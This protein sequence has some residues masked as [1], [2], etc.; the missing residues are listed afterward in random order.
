[1][2]GI[3]FLIRNG[4]RRRDAPA[5]YGLHKTNY[6]R[7]IRWSRLGVFNCIFAELPAKPDQ[8]RINATHLKAH[9]TAASTLKRGS[10]PTYRAHQRRAELQA[11]RRLRWQGPSVDHAAQRRADERLQ[12]RRADDC[13]FPKAKALHADRGYDADW[14]RAALEHR[15]IAQCIPSRA[16]RKGP[17]LHDTAIYRKRPNAKNMF[18]KLKDWRRIH[19]RYDRCARTFICAICIAAIVIFSLTQ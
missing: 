14:S 2:S 16:N 18:G 11:P 13:A 19:T 8:L 15:G 7:F 1:M 3:I 9:R 12:R 17:V 10:T 6:N 4:L 5:G